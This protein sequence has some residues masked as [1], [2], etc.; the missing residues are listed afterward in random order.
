MF[1]GEL[2]T[3]ELEFTEEMLNDIY[4]RFGEDINVKSYSDNKYRITVPIRI[5]PNFFLWMLGSK[6]K[7]HIMSPTNVIDSFDKFFDEIKQVY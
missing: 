5:S 1:D 4:D 3:V 7:I 2:E 6:G